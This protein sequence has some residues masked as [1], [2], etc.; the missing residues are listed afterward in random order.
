MKMIRNILFDFGGV[1]FRLN[2]VS[3]PIR[4]FRALGFEDAEQYLGIY[5]QRGLFLELETGEISEAQFLVELAAKCGRASVSFEE[6]LWAWMGYVRDVPPEGLAG[7]LR[8][9]AHYKLGLLS[10]T[11][12]FIQKWAR[13]ADF[14]GDG[15]SIY[16][17]VHELYCSHELHICKPSQVI[18]QKALKLGNMQADET[19]FLDDSPANVEA[20]RR[21]GMRGLLVMPDGQWMAALERCLGGES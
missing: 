17:Y 18:F 1:I 11:N 13:S 14:S 15:H 12:P 10:N 8:L 7:L 9:R 3:E 16:H 5:G 19:L 20:A 2:D 21:A 6:A 4:R